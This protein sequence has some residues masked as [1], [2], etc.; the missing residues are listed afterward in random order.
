MANEEV[1]HYK[2]S[3]TAKE[4]CPDILNGLSPKEFLDEK[5]SKGTFFGLDKLSRSGVYLLD[6]YSFDFKPYLKRFL[7]HQNGT[8]CEYYA[9]NKTKLKVLVFG[10]IDEIVEITS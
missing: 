6:G 9:P 2:F 3:A 5:Y 4:D 1:K 8:W 7:I 10:K